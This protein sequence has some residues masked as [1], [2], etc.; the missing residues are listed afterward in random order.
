MNNVLLIASA[1]I[2][3][4]AL[5]I[6]ILVGIDPNDKDYHKT[7]KSRI[8]LLTTFYIVTFVPALGF[9]IIYFLIR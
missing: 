2:C 8:T 9:A 5:I 7:A 4:I 6:T 1:I 3:V